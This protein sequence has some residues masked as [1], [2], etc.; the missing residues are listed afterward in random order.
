MHQILPNTIPLE[1]N[2]LVN[3]TEKTMMTSK[4]VVEN[5]TPITNTQLSPNC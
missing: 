4:H 2:N 1:N 5:T 3:F